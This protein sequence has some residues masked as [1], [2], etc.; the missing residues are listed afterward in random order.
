MLLRQ[1]NKSK[2][3]LSL[4][5]RSLEIV[6]VSQQGKYLLELAATLMRNFNRSTVL[7]MFASCYFQNVPFM[8]SNAIRPIS[9]ILSP[10]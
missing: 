8:L 10:S 2:F 9:S 6:A 1:Q 5:T 3:K 4:I 7:K